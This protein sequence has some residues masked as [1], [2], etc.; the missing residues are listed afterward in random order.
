MKKFIIAALLLAGIIPAYAQEQAP[1]L[2]TLPS[3]FERYTHYHVTA[4]YTGAIPLGSFSS[5]YIDKTSF[6]NYSIALEWVLQNSFSI[7]GELGY[8]FFN[9]R[10]PRAIYPTTDGSDISAI[11]TRTLTQYPIQI[12]GNYRFLGNNSAI[13]PYVQVSAG[14]SILDYTL[15]YGSL[16][17][18]KQKVRPTYGIGLGSKFLFKKDGNFGADVRVK[19]EATPFD[20]EYVDKGVS[21]LNASIG[22]FYR[23]W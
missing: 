7:G 6:E 21:S 16:A 10:I 9:K 8:S 2:Y 13:Q 22:L 4:R 23:W 20:Y 1:K 3:P 5:N 18:Q 14:A 17:D 15:Y 19:Y 12:F 11:Q